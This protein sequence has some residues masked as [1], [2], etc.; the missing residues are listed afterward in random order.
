MAR[1]W[2]W[3]EDEGDSVPDRVRSMLESRGVRRFS[4]IDNLLE[5]LVPFAQQGNDHT[6]SFG[7]ILDVMIGGS[8]AIY[9]PPSLSPDRQESIIL[10]DR[11]FDAGLVF[12]DEVILVGATEGGLFHPPP[13]VV[14]LTVRHTDSRVIQ[15]RLERIKKV[16]AKSHGVTYRDARVRWVRKSEASEGEI[17]HYLDE[18]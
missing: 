1:T 17:V 2:L 3:L 16:W 10:T 18:W 14:F 9:R 7:F 15:S 8:P 4:S 5:Y 11:G 6:T 12:Y 13:P